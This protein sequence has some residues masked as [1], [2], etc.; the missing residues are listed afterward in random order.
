[1]IE[2]NLMSLIVVLM[3]IDMILIVG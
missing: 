1:M 3:R 2:M